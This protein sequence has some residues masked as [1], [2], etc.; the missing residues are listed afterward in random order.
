MVS[1]RVRA[2]TLAVI[3]VLGFPLAGRAQ[4]DLVQAALTRQGAGDFAGAAE[5]LRTRLSASP[6][7]GEARRLLAQTLYWMG[8]VAGARTVYEAALARHPSDTRVRL[9]YARML[10]ETGDQ[11]RARTLLT[12][13]VEAPAARSGALS[14][15][16]TLAYWQGDLATAAKHFSDALAAN[17]QEADARRQLQEIRAITASWVKVS[18]GIWHDDQ[19]QTRAS[20]AIE[21]GWFAAP[22]TPVRARL[23]PSRFLTD[24]T[25]ATLWGG[26]VQIDHYAPA[27][28]IEMRGIAGL[29]RRDIESRQTEW[30][31]TG[32][33]GVR[34]PKHLTLRARTE[35]A[36]YL[37]TPASLSTSLMTR[38]VAGEARWDHRG[39]LGEAA[40]ERRLFPD[41]NA[42]RTVYAWL[43]APVARS[44]RAELQAGYA[45]SAD[46][47]DE[48]R[49]TPVGT[50]SAS[51]GRGS[52]AGNAAARLTGRFTPYYTPNRVVKHAL[53]AAVTG[54]PASG[55]TLRA[56]GSYAVR[57]FEDAPFLAPAGGQVEVLFARRELTAWDARG[58][59][60]I[61]AGRGTTVTVGGQ[62]GQGAFYRWRALEAAIVYRFLPRPT[63]S[64]GRR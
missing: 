60:E 15:L 12:P 44:R 18:P 64:A 11:A 33:A 47:A 37:A 17:P 8:D 45:F 48:T 25:T 55:I 52:G 10:L 6:G 36:P 54:R 5:L 40:V 21:A 51:P 61:A 29:V 28:R 13:L 2:V 23:L 63:A 46:N 14:L 38:A 41:D 53:V 56:G 50:P 16:G 58:S 34:L 35:R 57:A 42:I 27:A 1:V 7:D 24:G 62:V 26:E 39:W 43:L 9:D 4:D 49:F 20:A 19:P 22:L 30:T 31:A 32:V 3:A 59:V